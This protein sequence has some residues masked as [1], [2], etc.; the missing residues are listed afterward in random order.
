MIA[1]SIADLTEDLD[2]QLRSAATILQRQI[3]YGLTDMATIAFHEAG[4]ADRYVATVLT[5]RL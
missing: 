3:K 2:D 1:A 4:F 5:V